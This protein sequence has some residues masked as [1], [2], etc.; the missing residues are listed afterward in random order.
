MVRK[1]ELAAASSVILL[2]L[3]GVLTR[4]LL[5]IFERL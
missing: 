1:K 3:P 2:C 4:G 5:S